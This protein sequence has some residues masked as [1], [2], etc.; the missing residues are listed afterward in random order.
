MTTSVSD[1]PGHSL[2]RLVM[3]SGR[4]VH[5]RLDFHGL[6]VQVLDGAGLRGGRGGTFQRVCVFY[7]NLSFGLSGGSW[8]R[9]TLMP[10]LMPSGS[11]GFSATKGVPQSA[12]NCPQELSRQVSPQL[13]LAP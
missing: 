10:V 6:N 5:L 4:L 1:P 11:L 12:Q 9:L 3:W 8:C 7:H 2:L 13:I